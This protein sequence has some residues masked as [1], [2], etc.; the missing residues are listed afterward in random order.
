MNAWGRNA[1]R[2]TGQ[3]TSVLLGSDVLVIYDE[4]QTVELL[5]LTA[6]CLG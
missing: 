4:S 6:T 3:K 2:L 5:I 1:L